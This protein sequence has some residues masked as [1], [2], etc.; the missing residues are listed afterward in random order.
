MAGSAFNSGRQDTTTTP[1]ATASCKP[2]AHR[3]AWG[4]SRARVARAISFHTA[5]RLGI[6][7]RRIACRHNISSVEATFMP[8][9]LRPAGTGAILH[10]KERPETIPYTLS[11]RRDASAKKHGCYHGVLDGATF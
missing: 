11:V 10:E 9:R 6:R 5:G 7:G 8:R 2:N 1:A 4:A 3:T